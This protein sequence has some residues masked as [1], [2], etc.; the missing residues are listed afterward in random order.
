MP[1]TFA[2]LSLGTFVCSSG[3]GWL[4][5][6]EAGATIFAWFFFRA[7]V[8][9]TKNI[10]DLPVFMVLICMY[11]I[12]KNLGESGERIEFAVKTAL[13]TSTKRTL[14][15]KSEHHFSPIKQRRVPP[16]GATSRVSCHRLGTQVGCGNDKT[17]C[18]Q[19]V[20]CFL[21]QRPCL[22]K[23][24]CVLLCVDMRY[25]TIFVSSPSANCT[26]RYT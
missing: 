18:A 15:C 19:F 10:H 25:L 22:R 11:C 8:W 1:N 9:V 3:E 20:D 23:E 13:D 5:G 24:L 7:T 16:L 4:A 14:C 26:S 21:T 6:D 17:G 12:C 2:S